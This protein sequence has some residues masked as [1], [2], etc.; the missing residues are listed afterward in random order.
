MY[1]QAIFSLL[2]FRKGLPVDKACVAASNRD[3]K[4]Q[5]KP[6]TALRQPTLSGTERLW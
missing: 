3:H 6:W 1:G 5:F 4:R 2:M